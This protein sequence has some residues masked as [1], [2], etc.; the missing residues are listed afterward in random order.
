MAEH[1]GGIMLSRRMIPVVIF[2]IAFICGFASFSF[3]CIK[4]IS[5]AKK[6]IDH[7]KTNI[8]AMGYDVYKAKLKELREK[9]T[10]C[11]SKGDDRV[12]LFRKIM[13]RSVVGKLNELE[14]EDEPVVYPKCEDVRSLSECKDTCKLWRGENNWCRSRYRKIHKVFE[15]LTCRESLEAISDIFQKPGKYMDWDQGIEGSEDLTL[16]DIFAGSIY[17]VFKSE[18]TE[19]IRNAENL[20]GSLYIEPS[21]LVM[22]FAEIIEKNPKAM[23]WLRALPDERK[24][25]LF[26]YFLDIL[27]QLPEES[28]PKIAEALRNSFLYESKD[29]DRFVTQLL[30]TEPKDRAL[31]LNYFT[32]IAEQEEEPMNILFWQQVFKAFEGKSPTLLKSL[33]ESTETRDWQDL[34]HLLSEVPSTDQQEGSV[35]IHYLV[36]I[37]H[38]ESQDDSLN[39][40]SM[41]KALLAAAQAVYG[42]N[43]IRKGIDLQGDA[44]R[45]RLQVGS[46][47]DHGLIADPKSR[48]KPLYFRTVGSVHRENNRHSVHMAFISERDLCLYTETIVLDEDKNRNVYQEAFKNLFQRFNEYLGALKIVT[49]N[50]SDFIM[51]PADFDRIGTFIY[52]SL[53]QNSQ[54]EFK[55][56]SK[57]DQVKGVFLRIDHR[58]FEPIKQEDW[59][60]LGKMIRERVNRFYYGETVHTL[61]KSKT[62]PGVMDVHVRYK[63]YVPERKNFVKFNVQYR[64][65]TTYSESNLY[66]HE[67]KMSNEEAEKVKE[68]ITVIVSDTLADYLNLGPSSFKPKKPVPLV[69][70]S[71]KYLTSFLIPGY[72]RS[73]YEEE[74]STLLKTWNYSNITLLTLSILSEAIF[75]LSDYES[76]AFYHAGIIGVGL[77]AINGAWGVLDVSMYA[78]PIDKE[79][80]QKSPMLRLTFR[81]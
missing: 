18:K 48:E 1:L 9:L 73:Y 76:D 71:N 13:K 36:Q 12:D 30:Q 45:E 37:E 46:R 63:P 53:Y 39:V 65:G 59:K 41:N 67:K 64:M 16:A 14:S 2:T 74:P 70:P 3:A 79:N 40:L 47:W 75:I 17:K 27:S 28:L 56:K 10:L 26:R 35:Y 19:C 51:K 72:V 8:L 49:L 78:P 22:L 29:W 77:F 60:N 43:D 7:D 32:D 50:R 20:L 6:L 55:D 52:K 23:E 15:Y 80:A 57:F 25:S 34:K 21:K 81:F 5:E 69:E 24:K 11:S 4:P 33:V 42:K 31:L 66:V 58:S 61:W 62:G 38:P 44:V 68:V 54:F